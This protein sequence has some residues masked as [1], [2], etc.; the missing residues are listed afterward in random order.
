[1]SSAAKPAQPVRIHRL[2]PYWA[3]FQADIQQTMSSW[4]YRC[5]VVL[6]LLAALGYLLYRLGVYREAGIVQ[7]GSA[8]ISDLLRWTVIGSGTFVVVLTAGSISSE[9]GTMADS[10]LSRGISRYQYFMGKWHARLVTII[11]TYLLLGGVLLVC[12][13]MLLH[14]DLSPTGCVLALG[15]LAALL[16]VIITMGVTISALAHSTIVAIPLTW[17]VLYGTGFVLWLLPSHVPSPDRALEKLP[18]VLRGQYDPVLL[19]RLVLGAI[20]LT[21]ITAILGLISF[22]RRDV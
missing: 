21:C 13:V 8:F 4:I 20:L 9:R 7:M 2:L 18:F 12:S 5:W 1:M 10:V 3:V 15:T 11:G 16:A 19:E 22:A 6:S 17:L 14:E